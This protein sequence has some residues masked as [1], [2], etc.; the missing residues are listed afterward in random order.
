MEKHE[1]DLGQDMGKT[2]T[3]QRTMRLMFGETSEISW[4]DRWP[5]EL[6]AGVDGV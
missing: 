4:A 5:F 1:A 6:S 2:S 3:L